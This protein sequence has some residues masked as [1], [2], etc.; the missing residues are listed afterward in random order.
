MKK[1]ILLAGAV[2][3]ATTVS[4]SAEPG[5]GH[6]KSKHATMNH[7]KAHKAGTKASTIPGPT[8]I[9]FFMFSRS[10]IANLKNVSAC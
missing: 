6:G 2:M 7:G 9:T 8:L 4:A 3:L 5:K 10:R 1:L